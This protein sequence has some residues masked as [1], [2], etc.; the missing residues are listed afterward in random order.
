MN[1][2]QWDIVKLRSSLRYE[3]WHEN[4]MRHFVGVN[5]PLEILEGEGEKPWLKSTEALME[6]PAADMGMSA[7]PTPNQ[8]PSPA[9]MP[10]IPG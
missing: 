4:Y 8:L 3:Q 2:I 9:K 7:V 1:K 6:L 5:Q 10:P